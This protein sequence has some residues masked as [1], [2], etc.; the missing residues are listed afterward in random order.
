MSVERTTLLQIAS[1]EISLMQATAD[2]G[3]PDA[4]H[5]LRALAAAGLTPYQLPDNEAQD[6]AIEGLESL[7]AAI[8]PVRGVKARITRG[9]HEQLIATFPW[10]SEVAGTLTEV[11]EALRRCAVDI[12]DVTMPDKEEDDSPTTGQRI[13]LYACLKRIVRI[14]PE[15]LIDRDDFASA[16]QLEGKVAKEQLAQ[17]AESGD[18]FVVEHN[19]IDFYPL[20]GLYA[21]PPPRP[22]PAMKGIIQALQMDAWHIAIWFMAGCGMLGSR[23]PQDVIALDPEAVLTAAIDEGQGITHG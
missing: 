2:L 10:G 8:K 20:Y 14:G 12:S 3:L 21:D 16:V 15:G 5:T 17:W 4:G 19:G 6:L 11:V 23:R 7:R 18:I 1:G 13:Q 22:L 9:D